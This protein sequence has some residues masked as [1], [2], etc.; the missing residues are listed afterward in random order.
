MGQQMGQHEILRD[1]SS[2]SRDT[3]PK[4]PE[5]QQIRDAVLTGDEAVL[6]LSIERM[7]ARV[8]PELALQRRS[9]ATRQQARQLELE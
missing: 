9:A 4:A 3:G 2:R 6:D 1:A 8:V 5:R 7:V